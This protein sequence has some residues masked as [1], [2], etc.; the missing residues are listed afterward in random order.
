MLSQKHKIDACNGGRKVGKEESSSQY[1]P[2]IALGSL[3][4]EPS[5]KGPLEKHDL[6]QEQ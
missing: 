4:R 3:W 1:N 5:L 6:R 2:E